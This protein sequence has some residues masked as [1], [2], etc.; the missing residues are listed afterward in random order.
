[1]KLVKQGMLVFTAALLLSAPNTVDAQTPDSVQGID[2]R[3]SQFSI[4]GLNVT[5][6]PPHRFESEKMGFPSRVFAA[7]RGSG[8]QVQRTPPPPRPLGTVRP[9]LTDSSTGYIDNAI[10][11][12][13]VRIRFD[14]GFDVDA[15]DRAEFFYAKCGCYRFAPPNDPGFDPDAPGPGEV[16]EIESNLEFQELH[17]ELE[18]Q[19]HERLSVSV[20]VPVRAIQPAIVE[21]ATG[22]GDVRVGF[23]V[24][25]DASEDRYLTAQMRT[26]IPSG[27]ARRGL[28]TDHT[29]VEPAFLYHQRFGQGFAAAGQFAWWH[30]IGGSAGIP[31]SGD[32]DFAGDVLIYGLGVSKDVYSGSGFRLTPVIEFVGWSVLGGFQTAAE[33]SEADGVNI[34]NIKAGARMAFGGQNSVYFGYGKALTGAVWYEDL[35]RAEY[36][37]AF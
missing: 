9:R 1:M 11:G 31:A 4:H 36:R 35:F 21:K 16:G 27:D 19:L 30:P 2:A 25:L 32:K 22:F 26:Y 29:S 6:E 12:S 3:K 14:Y 8:F 5:P 17:F 13:Q 28:G 7:A 18:Y 34:A 37:F 10:V 23:K 20:D 24:A 33:A 15:P